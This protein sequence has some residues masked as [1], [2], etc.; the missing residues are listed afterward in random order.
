METAN[1]AV[2]EL[3]DANGLNVTEINRLIYATATPGIRLWQL[4]HQ[5]SEC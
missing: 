3:R 2:E 4:E 1:E 5:L